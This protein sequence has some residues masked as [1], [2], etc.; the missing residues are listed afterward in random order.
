MQGI[1]T[2]ENGVASND[3]AREHQSR[4]PD[5]WPSV[6]RKTDAE[7]A[8]HFAALLGLSSV[9]VL[10][11]PADGYAAALERKVNPGALTDAERA[12]LG[13]YADSVSKAR[14]ANR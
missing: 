9:A 14:S 5:S 2:H 4:L 1:G 6:E 3:R 13:S 11:A 12:Q 8:A 7:W 10:D